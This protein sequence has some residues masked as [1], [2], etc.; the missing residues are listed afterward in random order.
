MQEECLS[1][2]SA[3][4]DC[5]MPNE[6]IEQFLRFIKKYITPAVPVLVVLGAVWGIFTY[7]V[8]S[9]IESAVG[10]MRTDV[11]TL[12]T[13]VSGLETATGKTN[14]RIDTLLKDALERAFP[15]PTASKAEIRGSLKETSKLLEIAKSENIRLNPQLV[16]D[17]GKELSSISNDPSVSKLAWNTL[18][19]VLDYRSALNAQLVPKLQNLGQYRRGQFV[20]DFNAE[21]LPGSTSGKLGYSYSADEKM[22]SGSEAA[23]FVEIGNENKVTSAPMHLV[24]EGRGFNLILDGY[25]IRNVI[26]RD[27]KIT[28]NG[29][30]LILENV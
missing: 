12:K 4:Q 11:A 21:Q 26:V 8:R 14:E 30:S 1:P 23:M 10:G 16:S 2:H 18:S 13:Q 6:Q 27:A 20:V 9:E 17:Y 28:Y 5:R 15:R 7:T 22:V 29:G 24:I 19:D 3:P 25:H